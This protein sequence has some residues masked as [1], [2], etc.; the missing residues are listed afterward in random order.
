MDT[1]YQL[2]H[3]CLTWRQ[4]IATKEAMYRKIQDPMDR[5]LP[6]LDLIHLRM[7]LSLMEDELCESLILPP[8]L[9][10]LNPQKPHQA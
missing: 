10:E 9:Y 8:H 6:A 7:E 4:L 3:L 1:T 5:L 2:I